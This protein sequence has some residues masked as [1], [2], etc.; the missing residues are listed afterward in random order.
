[1]ISA[2]RAGDLH[3][4]PLPGHGVTPIVT[5]SGNTTINGMGAARVGDT[6]GCGAVIV[7]GFPSIMINGR[8]MAHLGSPT[9]H[10]GML[11]SG[12]P[13]V[14]GGMTFGGS[15]T[16]VVI[17]F[18]RLGIIAPNGSLDEQRL[19]TLLADPGLHDKARAAGALVAPGTPPVVRE[20]VC[21]HPDQMLDLA[22]YI[23]DEMNRNL[24][25]PTVL[26]IKQLLSY[27][28][29]EQTR[30]WMELPWYA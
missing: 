3:K 19:N 12:S 15:A 8:P 4:C 5:S 7:A 10:G 9:S 16:S 14:G 28:T 17:D 13:D 20:P 18:S 29:A 25:H 21:N 27:D 23:A 11:V 6:C 2:A 30:K 24:H 26:K 1:M 22:T